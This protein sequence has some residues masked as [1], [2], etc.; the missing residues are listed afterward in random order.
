VGGVKLEVIRVGGTLCTSV[1]ALQRFFDRLANHSPTVGEASAKTKPDQ[2]DIERQLDA[3][4]VHAATTPTTTKQARS[5][6]SPEQM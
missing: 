5:E 2:A 6:P 4:G 1:E 3:L